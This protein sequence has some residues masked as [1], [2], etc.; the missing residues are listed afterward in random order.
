VGIGDELM[1]TGM[2]REAQARDPRRVRIEYEKGRLRWSEIW[3]NNPRIAKYA[4]SGD[5]QILHP[6]SDYLR[7]YC[8]EKTPTRWTWR[9]YKPPV[10]EIYLSDS[11]MEFG[12]K[13]SG[14]VIL[15]PRIKLG[16]S[17]NKVWLD[18]YWQ[19]LAKLL[20]AENLMLAQL[21]PST[22]QPIQGVG[23]MHTVNFRQAAAIL[24]HARLV[25]TVEGAMHHA[26]AALGLPAVVIYGGYI[27]PEVTG[28]EGQAAFFRG[29]GLGCG[30][31]VRCNH[32]AQAMASIRPE[33]V[34]E[35]AMSV[36]R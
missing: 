20:R 7:P 10:G 22:I 4:E 31:R 3:D 36:M 13:A 34:F 1:V 32:C 18:R 23:L 29:D 26:A 12:K 17:P 6:R 35:A 27:S 8:V 14:F 33:E 2:A 30:M 24:K 11:E 28:Y 21:A 9:D 15:E 5:F 25:I 16:A 19:R